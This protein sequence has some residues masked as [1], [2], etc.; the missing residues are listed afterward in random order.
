MSRLP[1]IALVVLAVLGAPLSL[2]ANP[3][4]IRS[5]TLTTRGDA[6]CFDTVFDRAPDFTTVDQYGRN[7]DSFQF[8]LTHNLENP[9]LYR[10]VWIDGVDIQSGYVPVYPMQLDGDLGPLSASVPYALSQVAGGH[11][12]SF[13]VPY[14]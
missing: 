7:Y 11:L 8:T 14:D 1:S 3:L 4:E 12:L 9:Y 10:D 6:V 5:V 13:T 2:S